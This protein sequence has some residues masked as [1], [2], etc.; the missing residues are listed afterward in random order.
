[1]SEHA[2][3]RPSAAQVREQ[4]QQIMAEFQSN[5]APGCPDKASNNDPAAAGTAQQLPERAPAKAAAP[6]ALTPSSSTLSGQSLQSMSVLFDVLQQGPVSPPG[7][8]SS[9]DDRP[10][11]LLA[12]RSF[13]LACSGDAA[14]SVAAWTC[15]QARARGAPRLHAHP[16]FS[17]G[18]A[19][20]ACCG[21]ESFLHGPGEAC[22]PM[23]YTTSV[24]IGLASV[25]R[26]MSAQS[27][28]VSGW[29]SEG[30]S[31]MSCASFPT[32]SMA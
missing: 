25:M 8:Q 17:P 18:G 14:T 10:R 22:R 23:P 26:P 30:G 27:S 29:F 7:F 19:P 32:L 4:L 2:F 1:M 28:S 3:E 6:A 24:R 20:G 16:L 11:R 15:Q 21:S 9:S 12:S 13:S 31:S 5:S